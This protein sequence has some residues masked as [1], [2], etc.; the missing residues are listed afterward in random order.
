[1]GHGQAQGPLP[2]LHFSAA[3]WASRPC[4]PRDSLVGHPNAVQPHHETAMV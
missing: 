1:M 2:W 4:L 3:E